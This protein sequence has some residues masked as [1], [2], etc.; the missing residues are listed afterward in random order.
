M[1]NGHRHYSK[2]LRTAICDDRIPILKVG[3]MATQSATLSPLEGIEL[4]NCARANF[5]EGLSKTAERCGYGEDLEAFEENLQRA[6]STIGV[7]IDG[8]AELISE[9][10]VQP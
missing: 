2:F 3:L 4:I 10:Q 9:W 8:L 6:C 1:N 7:E 5:R